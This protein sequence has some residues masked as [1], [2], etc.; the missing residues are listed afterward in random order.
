VSSLDIE[1]L[2]VNSAGNGLGPGD[3]GPGGLPAGD[4][5]PGFRNPRIRFPCIGIRRVRIS[6]IVHRIVVNAEERS[7]VPTASSVG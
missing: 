5:G 1:V 4:P 3:R 2:V 6:R 7:D